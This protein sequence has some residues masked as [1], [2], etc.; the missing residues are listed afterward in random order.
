MIAELRNV[1]KV[2]ADPRSGRGLVALNDVSLS[3]EEGEFLCLV[4]SSGCGKSTTL[5]LMAGFEAPS[6]GQMLFRG[7]E[8]SGPSPERGVVFQEP[9]LFPWMSVL[10]NVMFSL[11]DGGARKA[12]REERAME[13]LRLVGLDSF[14]HAR[15]NDLSGGMKQRVAIAR[16]LAME[17]EMLLMDEPFGSLDEQTRRKLDN[18]ALSLWQ[19]ERKTVVFVTHNIDEALTLGTRVVL[20]SPSPGRIEREWHIDEAWPR[21]LSSPRMVSLRQEVV[22]MLQACPC[23]NGAPRPSLLTLE[24]D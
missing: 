19:R 20:M 17:P 9:S 4:G 14:A 12:V 23:A 16:T 11:Q 18:E 8:V 13:Q 15:P 22:G 7:E 10:Q 2:F 24:E 21:D 3:I 5:N 1:S 6:R